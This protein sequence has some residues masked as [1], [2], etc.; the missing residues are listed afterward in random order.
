MADD[1]T[2]VSDPPELSCDDDDGFEHYYDLHP[3][4]EDLMG[5]SAAQA[6][7]IATS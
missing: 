1:N 4:Q 5:E 7:L 3:T 6:N 2:L